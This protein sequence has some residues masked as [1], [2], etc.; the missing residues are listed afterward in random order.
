MRRS[1]LSIILGVGASSVL[2]LGC[3]AVEE[4]P[5]SSIQPLQIGQRTCATREPTAEEKAADQRAMNERFRMSNAE[6]GQRRRAAVTVN[7]YVHVLWDPAD[8]TTKVPPRMVNDQISVL[9]GAFRD[10]GFVFELAELNYV[11]NPK[12]ATECHKVGVE[13]QFK[14]ALRRGT[15]QDLNFY[16][17][18]LGA[19]LLGYA[20]F[21]PWYAKDPS[22]DGVVV[23]DQS[24]PG[25]SATN[26]DEGDTGTH[27]VGH[28]LGLYHTFQ[29]GCTGD[30]DLISDTPPEA[31]P[32][33][34]C[35]IGRDTCAGGGEDPIHNFMDYT[36][37]DCMFEFTEGQGSR[38]NA[39][40]ETYRADL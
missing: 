32:A 17:C 15:A 12:W 11:E 27:E 24:L 19:N 10:H 2:G 40:W 22:R 36:Y 37:D 28:W 35:P 23:L 30:G 34:G 8:L 18:R 20:T 13:K 21:P 9:T 1:K 5:A 16:V 26:Y 3:A 25:G 31:S 4:P 39:Q 29:G 38:M 33:F 14:A 6:R 7:T